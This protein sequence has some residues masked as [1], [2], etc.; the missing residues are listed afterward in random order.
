MITLISQ[1]FDQSSKQDLVTVT[2]LC[3]ALELSRATF[4]RQRERVLEPDPDEM[5]IRDHIQRIALQWPSYGYRMITVEL[6]R[7][8]KT[9]P[10]NHKR[11]LRMMREDKIGRASCRERV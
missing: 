5:I 4:Y 7:R 10:V 11:V 8:Y 9:A 6:N 2:H 3:A 1:Q